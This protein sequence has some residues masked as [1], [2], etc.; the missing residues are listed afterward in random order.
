MQNSEEKEIIKHNQALKTLLQPSEMGELFKVIALTKDIDID[1][2]GF[3][4][5]DKR[6]S[7]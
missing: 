4:F 7:L 1:L 5:N 2:N 6:V 3:K